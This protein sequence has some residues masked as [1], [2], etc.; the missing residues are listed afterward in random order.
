MPRGR[1]HHVKTTILSSITSTRTET[2]IGGI[3]DLIGPKL[4]KKTSEYVKAD[5]SESTLKGD[6]QRALTL[7]GN[8]GLIAHEGPKQGG[9]WRLTAEGMKTP[10]CREARKAAK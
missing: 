3:V 8:A 7:L 6:A 1:V 9:H 2:T 5:G 10:E 4:L